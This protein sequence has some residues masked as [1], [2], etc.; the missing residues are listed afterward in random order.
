MEERTTA[1]TAHVRESRA[2]R[3]PRTVQQAVQRFGAS[4][5]ARYDPPKR[6]LAALTAMSLCHSEALGGHVSRCTA[7]GTEV[8]RYNS[9]QHSFCPTCRPFEWEQRAAKQEARLLPVRHHAIVLKLP[10][11]LREVAWLNQR[12]VLYTL[13]FHAAQQT[14]ESLAAEFLGGAQLAMTMA[15]HT[16][17]RDLLVD[18]HLHILV[19]AGGLSRDHQRWVQAEEGVFSE[20]RLQAGFRAAM[21]KGLA[22]LLSRGLL[23][24]VRKNAASLAPEAVVAATP[25]DPS[26]SESSEQA[27]VPGSNAASAPEPPENPEDPE[28]A[29]FRALLESLAEK[30]WSAHVEVAENLGSSLRYMIR[31]CPVSDSRLSSM[32]DTTVVLATHP[33]RSVT[34]EG[35]ELL[36]RLMLH[37]PPRGAC[38]VH[39]FG[40]YSSGCAAGSLQRAWSLAA[41]K[42][43][44]G[45]EPKVTAEVGTAAGRLGETCPVCRAPMVVVRE[46]PVPDW[47][48]EHPDFRLLPWR[49]R[50][51]RR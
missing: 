43:M 33:G 22:S 16:A 32:T 2:A 45:P 21:L 12:E 34:L 46:I 27:E 24:L 39:H 31:R 4:Y 25:A 47:L 40:L 50:V 19:P 42:A 10:W 28:A 48:F 49:I 17:T 35:V 9:C 15:L 29:R 30:D 23:G 13:M 38:R 11:E 20:A 5:V 6:V 51:I 26:A 44:P 14:L 3:A 8:P 7:C 36:R 18:P 1:A 41:G 37:L